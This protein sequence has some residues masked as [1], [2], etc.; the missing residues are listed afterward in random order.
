M[1]AAM[2]CVTGLERSSDSEGVRCN[3][4]ESLI[5]IKTFIVVMTLRYDE[6]KAIMIALPAFDDSH[7]CYPCDALAGPS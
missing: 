5:T 4:R 6:M 1:G 7:S 3:H 2:V